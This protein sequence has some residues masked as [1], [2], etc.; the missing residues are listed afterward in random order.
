[1][2]EPLSP[3]STSLSSQVNLSSSCFLSSRFISQDDF[4]V[5]RTGIRFFEIDKTKLMMSSRFRSDFNSVDR[6]RSGHAEI[7]TCG[8]RADPSFQQWVT[9]DVID[10]GSRGILK[11]AGGFV[12]VSCLGFVCPAW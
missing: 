8:R 11:A 5:G 12:D 9:A 6:A 3:S 10:A 7:R 4:L 1:M 2:R